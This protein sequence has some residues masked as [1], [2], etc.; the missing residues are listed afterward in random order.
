LAPTVSRYLDQCLLL[1]VSNLFLFLSINKSTSA[2]VACRSLSHY[3][4]SWCF[5]EAI[6]I[7]TGIS[8][9]VS[10]VGLRAMSF[11]SASPASANAGTSSHQPKGTITPSG[12]PSLVRTYSC[13]SLFS[14]TVLQVSWES[15]SVRRY[16]A[17]VCFSKLDMCSHAN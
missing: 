17:D 1:H 8:C 14:E 2:G 16:G 9:P 11:R 10:A 7:P 3:A 5:S 12:V 4:R 6:P 13:E 15:T